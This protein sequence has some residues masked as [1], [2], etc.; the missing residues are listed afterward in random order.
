[1]CGRLWRTKM[2]LVQLDGNA[3]GGLNEREFKV[4]LKQL[5]VRHNKTEQG[6]IRGVVQHFVLRD[7]RAPSTSL[8]V[9]KA[10]KN[11]GK[12]G[13]FPKLAVGASGRQ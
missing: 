9:P 8:L 11:S 3:S 7:Q 1:M 6:R 10:S 2:T 13:Q 12:A 5:K 4:L